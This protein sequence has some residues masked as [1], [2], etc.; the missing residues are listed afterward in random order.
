MPED[1][2]IFGAQ[3]VEFS[4]GESV[5]DVMLREMKDNKIHF[6]FVHTPM[7]DSAYIEGIG[8]LYEFD[9]GRHSGWMYRV[10]G[11]SPNYGCSQYI[12]KNGDKIEFYYNCD[13]FAK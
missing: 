12:L 9:C 11:E 1:G 10:N 8:N 4:E 13:M 3:I 5:F 7:Y 6:E 2:I